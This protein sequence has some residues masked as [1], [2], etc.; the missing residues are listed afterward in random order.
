MSSFDQACRR[1]KL[2]IR[3]QSDFM[4]A[5]RSVARWFRRAW[6][7]P[8]G[9]MPPALKPTNRALDPATAVVEGA[10]ERVRLPKGLLVGDDG[11]SAAL[12]GRPVQ[13]VAA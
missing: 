8:R 9:E 2:A 7:K 10:V 11:H 1:A 12:D 3:N 6:R 4:A 5:R 13:A